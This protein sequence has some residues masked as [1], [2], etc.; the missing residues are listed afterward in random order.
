MI[1]A[2]LKPCLKSWLQMKTSNA[3][4]GMQRDNPGEFNACVLD[5]LSKQRVG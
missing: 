1:H 5:F 3:S 2:A 4:H